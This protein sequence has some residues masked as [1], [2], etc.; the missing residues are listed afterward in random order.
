MF[1]F[2]TNRKICMVISSALLL[3]SFIL[4]S[5]CAINEDKYSKNQKDSIQKNQITKIKASKENV[6]QIGKIGPPIPDL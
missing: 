6:K 4:F 2:K 5:G 3:L 1:V